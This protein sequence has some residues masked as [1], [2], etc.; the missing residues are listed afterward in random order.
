MGATD[1]KLEESAKDKSVDA[2]KQK[3]KD[4]QA[5]TVA[6]RAKRETELNDAA[7]KVNELPA[8]KAASA[9]RIAEAKAKADADVAQVRTRIAKEQTKKIEEEAAKAKEK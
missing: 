6:R 7:A 4:E 8:M 9:D 5:A 3:E 2:S 1:K